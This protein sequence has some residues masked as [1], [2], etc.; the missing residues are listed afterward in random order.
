M[1]YR[2]VQRIIILNF[3]CIL[4]ISSVAIFFRYA[5]NSSL[6]WSD[7]IIRY[8][9]VWLTFSAS[10]LLVK[11]DKHIKVELLLEHAGPKFKVVLTIINYAV[12]ILMVIFFIVGGFAWMWKVAGME[13]PALGLPIEWILYGAL[14]VS[15]VFAL[16]FVLKSAKD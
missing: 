8:L 12:T 2:A 6:Y 15:F 9:F 11:E 10:S 14:P 3:A 5:L 13:S 16:W 4:L 7:E 1:M